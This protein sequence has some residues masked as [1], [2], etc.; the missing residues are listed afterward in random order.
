MAIVRKVDLG[1]YGP[2]TKI[3]IILSRFNLSAINNNET[4]VQ[5]GA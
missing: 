4:L 3:R 5:Q 1:V 2:Y